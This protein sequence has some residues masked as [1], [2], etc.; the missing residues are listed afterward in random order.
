MGSCQQM[1]PAGSRGSA[2]FEPKA[3]SSQGGQPT[4]QGEGGNVGFSIPSGITLALSLPFKKM[5]CN[6]LIILSFIND[7]H[8]Y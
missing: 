5:S 6:S 7:M 3:T 2:L 1:P 8:V 4:A